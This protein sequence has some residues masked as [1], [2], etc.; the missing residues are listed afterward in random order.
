MIFFDKKPASET[1]WTRKLWIYDLRTNK[2]F[3]LKTNPLKRADLDEFVALYNPANRH[4]RQ[5]TWTPEL[6]SGSEAGMT[7][8]GRWR[9]YDYDELVAR[10]KASLDIFWL[11]DE[12]LADSANLPPPEVIA[13]EIVD[14]LQAALRDFSAIA[15]ALSGEEIPPSDVND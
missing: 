10:D 7:P 11:K 15:E 8:D 4:Q 12:S 3:T 9:A 2:H 1:P 5:T 14:E 6:D 13:Q